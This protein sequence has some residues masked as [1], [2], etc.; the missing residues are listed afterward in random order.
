MHVG[1]SRQFFVT[2]LVAIICCHILSPAQ[3][4]SSTCFPTILI[5]MLIHVCC[6]SVLNSNVVF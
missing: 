6:F 2:K 4:T 5:S 3:Q 1:I